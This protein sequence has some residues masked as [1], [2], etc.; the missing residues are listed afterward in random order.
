MNARIAA[1]YRYPVKSMDGNELSGVAVGPSGMPG[2]RGWALRETATGRAA[3]AKRFPSLML[4]KARY[5]DEPVAGSPP[6]PAEVVLPDG[7]I[8]TTDNPKANALLSR[9]LGTDVVFARNDDGSG[10][11]DDRPL[12][13]LTTAALATLRAKSGLDF[14]VR[15]FRPNVLIEL[16]ETGRPEDSWIGKT[17]TIGEISVR[18]VKPV[19]RCVMTTLPQPSLA[20]E[21]GVLGMILT[22]G[23]ALGVYG[24]ALSAGRWTTG[25][26]IDLD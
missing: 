13:L 22:D 24:K 4:C 8:T 17:L 12:H 10:H 3:S 9:L 7:N 19:K 16:D 21:R 1:L 11:F 15:R 2:D 6:P 18:V 20:E 14:D 25:T 5:S 23:G 26:K